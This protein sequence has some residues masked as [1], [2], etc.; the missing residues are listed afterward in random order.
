M[1][2]GK[3]ALQP[4]LGNRKELALVARIEGEL[5][6]LQHLGEQAQHLT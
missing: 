3:Q 1:R 5:N 4:H 6:L 2:A